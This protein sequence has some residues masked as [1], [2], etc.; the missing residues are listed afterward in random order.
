MSAPILYDSLTR[1][2]GEFVKMYI[3]S[4][5]NIPCRIRH[6]VVGDGLMDNF[7]SRELIKYRA[8][9]RTDELKE[10]SLDRPEY[11][12]V[13]A[14]DEMPVPPADLNTRV[15]KHDSHFPIL[16]LGISL[17]SYDVL[18]SIF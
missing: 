1:Y 17:L 11:R 5:K 15:S 6:I 7:P 3:E 12:E 2:G 13:S 14:Y 9:A 16:V 4:I 10:L 8:K 18:R